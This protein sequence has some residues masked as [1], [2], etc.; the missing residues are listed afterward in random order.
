LEVDFPASRV[1]ADGGLILVRELDER[2]GFGDLITHH[3]TDSRRAE[4]A[5]LPLA[6]LF[7]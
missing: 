2:M 7:R 3:L 4:N 1:T 5:Q 6:D